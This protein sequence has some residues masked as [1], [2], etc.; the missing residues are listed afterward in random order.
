MRRLPDRTRHPTLPEHKKVRVVLS[1]VNLP[2]HPAYPRPVVSHDH[3]N[4][5]GDES[6]SL[7]LTHDLDVRESLP[8]EQTSSWH[9]LSARRDLAAPCGL[10]SRHRR[11]VPKRLRGTCSRF[12]CLCRYSCNSVRM[13]DG[14]NRLSRLESA[15]MEGRRQRSLCFHLRTGDH[16]SRCPL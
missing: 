12:G 14:R 8:V 16:D 1:R 10:L 9:S 15:C 13:A 6:Q 2:G 11:R 4:V 7:I 5:F 3:E